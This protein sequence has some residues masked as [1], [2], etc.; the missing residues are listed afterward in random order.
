MMI[1]DR[2]AEQFRDF[3]DMVFH[4]LHM[5]LIFFETFMV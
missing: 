4:F 2:I 3:K 1:I 5:I